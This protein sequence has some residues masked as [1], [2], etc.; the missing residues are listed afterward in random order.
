MNVED[1]P[2]YIFTTGYHWRGSQSA[3]QIWETK[4]EAKR[5]RGFGR[6]VA[7]TETNNRRQATKYKQNSKVNSSSSNNISGDADE[8]S[9]KTS[10][11]DGQFC[12][13]KMVNSLASFVRLPCPKPWN[14]TQGPHISELQST[15]SIF[16]LLLQLGCKAVTT[17]MSGFF[18]IC[19]DLIEFSFPLLF[20]SLLSLVCCLGVQ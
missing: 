16:L 13:G 6:A 5:T 1:P 2:E 7:R 19:F 4:E 18:L 12:Y 14:W 10:H 17:I 11:A 8:V 20:K 9:D 15:H 3:K